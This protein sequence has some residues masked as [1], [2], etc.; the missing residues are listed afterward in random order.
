MNT[1]V[2]TGAGSGVGQELAKRLAAEGW[3]VAAVGRRRDALEETARLA[4]GDAIGVFPCDVGD[5]AAVA[6][7]AEAVLSR[8]GRVD[9]LVNNAGG[10]VPR[11]AWTEISNDD[12]HRVMAANLHGAFHCTRAFL[13]AMRARG[14]GTIVNVVSEAGKA[15]SPKAGSAY[16]AA[17]FGLAGLTQ[18]INAEER[19][20]GIRASAIFP[21]DID[22]PIL[23]QRPVPPDAAARA[24]MLQADDVARCILFCLAQPP[25]V[26]VEEL[27]V[28]PR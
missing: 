4:G 19:A 16:V 8:Y 11:R 26:L 25:H 17:K 15:A 22:T 27:V 2:V 13:P 24:R 12:Y 7:M 9:A 28:R 18:S 10:N 1:A 23:D 21:G 20:H 5:A 14:A 6:V 3:L